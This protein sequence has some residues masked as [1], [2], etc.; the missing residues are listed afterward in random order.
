[1]RTLFPLFLFLVLVTSAHSASAACATLDC[2]L[3]SRGG[4]TVTLADL[5]AKLTTLDEKS[6]QSLLSDAK[7]LGNVI[8]NLLITRQLAQKVDSEQALADPVIK[9]RVQQ[10]M[11]EVFSVHQLDRIRAE[12]I[13]GDFD[14]LAREHYLT[15][16]SEMVRGREAVV[17][18]ILIDTNQRSDAEAKARIDALAVTLANADQKAFA[19]AVYANSDDPGRGINGGIY[20]VPAGQSEFDPAFAAAALALEKPGQISPPVKTQFGYHLIQLLELKPEGTV[21]FEDVRETIVERLRQDAR[22]RVVSEYRSEVMAE[23]ELKSYPENLEA[24]ARARAGGE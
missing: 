2:P 24:W 12:R 14:R 8:E 16:K 9:A 22:R 4:A 20:T 6:R 7:A 5:E 18:H 17:R 13:Q 15:H 1:M 10:L 3:A 19:D 23:G 21:P 11:D